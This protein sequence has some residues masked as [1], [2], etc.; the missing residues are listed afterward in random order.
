[1]PSF[2]VVSE[3]DMQEVVNAVD[4]TVREITTRY[5]FKGS[6][7]KVELNEKDSKIEVLADDDMR[8][9]AIQDILRQKL[10]K[11]SINL[12]SVEFKEA[13]KAG[14]DMLRQ[15]VLVKQGLT[16][17]EMKRIN[18]LIK[19]S[20]L[21]LSSQIQG[22]QLRVTGKKKDELQSIIAHLKTNVDDIALQF[23]NFRD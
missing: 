10:A 4:Q 5:D 11:R 2:D 19:D 17:E 23:V 9:T 8:L 12:K 14:G 21:K 13:K 1:M 7:A 22:E 20:K 6:K 15:E 16:Q 18:K 3:V